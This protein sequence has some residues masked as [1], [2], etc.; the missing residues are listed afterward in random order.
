MS[1]PANPRQSTDENRDDELAYLSP[2]E[3]PINLQVAAA[4]AAVVPAAR[5]VAAV[6][7]VLRDQGVAAGEVSLVVAGDALLHQLNRNYRGVDAVTDVLS[8][9]ALAPGE[10]GTGPGAFVS[11]PEA[12]AY[13]GD[14]VISYPAAQR[15]AIDAGHTVEDELCLLAVHGT[16]HLLGHDHATAADEARMWMVQETVL[17]SLDITIPVKRHHEE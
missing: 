9:P 1:Q 7:A 10:T 16:L 14:V 13:L 8:F 5:L 12:A 6:D 4:Y 11:A 3:G 2:V 17:R 15:H